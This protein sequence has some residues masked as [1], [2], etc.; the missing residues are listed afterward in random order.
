MT[1]EQ[2]DRGIK[3]INEKSGFKSFGQITTLNLLE[4][5]AA[6]KDP[7]PATYYGEPT[8]E[9]ILKALDK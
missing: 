2:L 1:N 6:M 5:L 8:K 7:D 9:E 3:W 4:V